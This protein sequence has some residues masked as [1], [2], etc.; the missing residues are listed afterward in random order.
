MSNDGVQAPRPRR[1][2]RNSSRSR[3][4]GSMEQQAP[5]IGLG[6]RIS[7][8]I[9]MAKKGYEQLVH[10]I[11]RPPRAKYNMDQLG[12]PDFT[13]LGQ[14]Y[15]R[16]DVELLSSNV[17]TN[18][19]VEGEKTNAEGGATPT[20]SFLKMQASIWTRV[21]EQGDPDPYSSCNHRGTQASGENGEE[22]EPSESD[23]PSPG[24]KRT[25]VVYLHGNASARVEVVPNLSFLLGQV[26]VFGVVGVDFTGSGKSDG[27]YVSLGYYERVDLECL[28]QYLKSVYGGPDGDDLEL[29]LWGRS[30][31]ASTALMHAGKKSFTATK[32]SRNHSN[33]DNSDSTDDEEDIVHDLRKKSSSGSMEDD[34]VTNSA[35]PSKNNNSILKGLICDSPFASLLHLCEE[36]VER[37][38]AQGVVVPG[39]V[40]SVAIAMI[41]RSVRNLAGFN[42]REITPIEDVPN[43]D[44]PALFVVGADDDF[45]TPQHS[46]RLVESYKQGVT[47]NLFMVPGGHNDARPPIVFEGILEF[48]RQRLSLG[49]S[50]APEVPPQM[51]SSIHQNPPWAYHRTVH[52]QAHSTR[53]HNNTQFHRTNGNA[54]QDAAEHLGMTQERQ[55]DIQNKIG[56][57]M[58]GQG[59][60]EKLRYSSDEENA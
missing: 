31:G 44:V 4:D 60:V 53:E 38:R 19:P 56:L 49:E 25:M 28:I 37:A 14:R 21:G 47:T 26:G 55:D 50:P 43:I 34:I 6:A 1:I 10:A 52:F 45:I 30:M 3:S 36:L 42:I 5:R 11:I 8:N 46:E 57:M 17:A 59:D 32:H 27:D 48:C 41:A 13:F 7:Q 20:C 35:Q 23:G 9:E 12:P 2:S 24:K 29:I 58:G 39:V 16:D 40:I 51:L 33:R 15:R 18:E 54:A 22:D